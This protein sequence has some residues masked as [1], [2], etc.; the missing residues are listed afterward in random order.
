LIYLA[1]GFTWG[2][3]LLF[4]K[5]LTL[6]AT[7]WRVLPLH[8][9][10]LLLGWTAQLAMGVAFWILPRI[11]GRRG[12]ETLAWLAFIL[13]NVGVWCVGLG[14]WFGAPVGVLLAGRV[15]EGAAVVVFGAHAWGRIRPL[16]A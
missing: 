1:I 14:T 4:H 5:G 12:N 16:G 10:L 15:A 13:L 8:V 3:L 11:R 7:L 2:G 6:Y 9:E